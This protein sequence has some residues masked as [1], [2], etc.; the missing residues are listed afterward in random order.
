M[1]PRRTVRI[2][3]NSKTVAHE[4]KTCRIGNGGRMEQ[5]FGEVGTFGKYENIVA[6]RQALWEAHGCAGSGPEKPSSW[7]GKGRVLHRKRM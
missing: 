4:V 5:W 2:V 6:M 7:G 3:T 1:T